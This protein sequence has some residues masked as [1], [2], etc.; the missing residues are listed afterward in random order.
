MNEREK[1]ENKN[2]KV[3]ASLNFI[4]ERQ[5]KVSIPGVKEQLY[6]FDRVYW[7]NSTTQVISQNEIHHAYQVHKVLIQL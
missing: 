7:E 2:A 1:K 6:G 4:N 5:L 3:N